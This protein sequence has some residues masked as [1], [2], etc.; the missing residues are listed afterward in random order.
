MTDA[1]ARERFVAFVEF[2]AQP[3]SKERKGGFLVKKGTF[4]NI[5]G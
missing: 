5:C 2:L 1:Q 4:S 3:V